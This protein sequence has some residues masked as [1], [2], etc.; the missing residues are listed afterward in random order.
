M[1]KDK[2]IICKDCGNPFVFSASEQ[3]FYAEKGFPNE[4][5][6]CPESPCDPPVMIT[7]LQNYHVQQLNPTG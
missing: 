3:R 7:V 2:I 1:F 4:P 6:R 5:V